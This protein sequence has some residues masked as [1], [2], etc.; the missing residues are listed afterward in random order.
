MHREKSLAVVL[1]AIALLGSGLIVGCSSKAKDAQ[2]VTNIQSQM[3]ADAQLKTANLH[4]AAIDGQVTL[5]GTVPNDAARYDAYKIATQTP[6]VKKV[7]DQMVIEDQG[8]QAN[9]DANAAPASDAA[10]PSPAPTAAPSVAP[11]PARHVDLPKPHMAHHAKVDDSSEQYA[12]ASPNSNLAPP[13]STEQSSSAMPPAEQ[14][15]PPA[16]PPVAP[17]LPPAA[18]LP[19]PPPPPKQYVVP[20][21]TT[22]SIRMID[23]VD[24]SVNQPGEVFQASLDAPIVVGND[25]VVPKGANVYVRL[26]S[27]TSAGK[28]S[29]QSELRLELV[30]LEYQGGSFPLVSTTYS[31][32]GKSRTKDTEKKVGGG[33]ILGAI[34]GAVA[35]G[36]KGAAIGAAAGAGAGGVYQGATHGQQVKIP[37]ETKLDFQLDQPATITVKQ[38]SQPGS[39]SQS[40]RTN[41][42][43]PTN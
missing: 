5:K 33:A 15:P 23:S 35:G 6:G 24:S 36:G 30:K 38:T 27:A 7:N 10:A 13:A 26:T 12:Q 8:T 3:F 32:Q 11:P 18:P 28:M 40:V 37:S 43:Q 19:P 16:A 14:T 21:G 39:N 9:A 4:V 1:A 42:S 20:A 17:P 25:V 29:G 41:Y 34:I 22:V 2:L 31:E